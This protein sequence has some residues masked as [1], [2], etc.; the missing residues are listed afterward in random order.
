M[1]KLYLLTAVLLA[2]DPV[3]SAWGINC[4]EE[5]LARNVSNPGSKPISFNDCIQQ[6]RSE[7]ERS[8]FQ[9][10]LIDAAKDGF[11]KRC[12]AETARK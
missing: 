6:V 4:S 9:R 10:K 3:S 8:A 11:M 7:C 2:L 5:A 1:I 12:L